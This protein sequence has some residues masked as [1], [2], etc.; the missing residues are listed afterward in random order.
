[1]N[2]IT[3]YAD[4]FWSMSYDVGQIM[5]VVLAWGITFLAIW[6]AGAFIWAICSIIKDKFSKMKTLK[7][8]SEYCTRHNK[9]I[10][11]VDCRDREKC[12]YGSCI[13]C[14]HLDRKENIY[15]K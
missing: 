13:Y 6:F 2:F 1:M 12:L 15:G 10:I 8:S 3:E 11:E 9:L 7:T 5:K 14:E 4:A